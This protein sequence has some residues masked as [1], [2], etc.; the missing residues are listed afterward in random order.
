M[1]Q[2]LYNEGAHQRGT[3]F[4]IVEMPTTAVEKALAIC[5]ALSAVPRGLGVGELAAELG[6]PPS[7]AHRLLVLLKRQGYVQQDDD[8][9]KYAL[10]LKMLDLSFRLLGRSELRLHAYPIVRDHVLRSGGLRAFIALPETGDVTYVWS[11]GP[12]EVAMHT[13]YGK[14][15]PGHC[16]IY[17]PADR[18]SRRLSCLR[19]ETRDDLDRTASVVRRL[20]PT[21]NAGQLQRLNCTCAPVH[22]YA[23]RIVARVG[24][25]EHGADERRLLGGHPRSAWELARLI[26]LRLGYLPAHAAETPM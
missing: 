9:G 14:E 3:R 21:A 12:D 11:T 17:F 4:H 8:T 19:L 10:S 15:M 22:D 13:V 2:L 6:L 5:E 1:S 23:G 25:F 26:S 18:Q 7:T 20:G 24:L 16:A